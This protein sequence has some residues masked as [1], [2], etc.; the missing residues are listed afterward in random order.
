MQQDVVLFADFLNPR[1]VAFRRLDDTTARDLS[2]NLAADPESRVQTL[3]HS[4]SHPDLH[5][6]AKELARFSDDPKVRAAKLATIPKGV[7]ETHLLERIQGKNHGQH[8]RVPG[9]GVR[10]QWVNRLG[11]Q[12]SIANEHQLRM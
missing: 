1:P 3:L 11:E 6:I 12:P 9:Q 5:V 7:V 2:G 8:L 10:Q 4:R